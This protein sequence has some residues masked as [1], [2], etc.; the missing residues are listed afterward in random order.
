MSHRVLVYGTLR[1][2]ESN[3]H[4][5]SDSQF[6]GHVVTQ[7][8]FQLFD[9]GPYPAAIKGEQ[10]LVAEVYFVDEDTMKQLDILEDYPHEYDR[11]LVSTPHGQ[12]WIYLYQNKRLLTKI[13]PSGDWCQR[14]D[15]ASGENK[16]N[17]LPS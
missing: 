9:L 7:A 16:V 12:A 4:L 15:D 10:S 6:L 8:Q 2:G 1:Q 11:E 3:H 13:I 17:F 14:N 5:L